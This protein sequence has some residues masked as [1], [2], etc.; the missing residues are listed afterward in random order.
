MIGQ[1]HNQK[2]TAAC[3]ECQVTHRTSEVLL[4]AGTVPL[5]TVLL[6]LLLA[7]IVT[8]AA[9]GWR[10]LYEVVLERQGPT[11]EI[12]E[13]PRGIGIAPI[14]LRVLLKDNGSGLDEV[15]VRTIQRGVGKEVLR[16]TLEGRSR[17]EVS[18]DFAG[19]KSGLDEGVVTLEI[20]AFDRSFWSNQAE[21]VL[22]LKV[23][24]RRPRLE[25]LTSF[26]NARRGGSQ[27]IFYRVSDESLAV[28]GVKVGTTT[29]LGYSARG[30]DPAF[31]DPTIY[32]AFYAIDLNANPE[33]VSIKLF[34]E[35]VVGNAA[36]QSFSNKVFDRAQRRINMPMSEVL[37][38]GRL[39]D[40]VDTNLAKIEEF[41]RSRGKTVNLTTGPGK[42]DRL[43][44]KF[45]LLNGP[46]REMSESQLLR[47]LKASR[48][49][50]YWD[51]P[52]QTV[53]GG[54]NLA[55]GD[56]V[57]FVLDRAPIGDTVQRGYEVLMS[58]DRPEVPALAG[59]IVML[60]DTIGVFGRTVAIDHGFGL[61]TIYGYLDTV[62]VRQG[63]KI[64]AGQPI[65]RAGESGLARSLSTFIQMRVHG[66]SV[67]PLEWWDRTWYN[68]HIEGKIN[69]VKRALGLEV[70]QP[71]EKR[72]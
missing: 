5:R 49:E 23:D 26:H 34:A 55:F 67:D 4:Q 31:E 18:V 53:A 40:L 25:P 57:S 64:V 70:L 9:A 41:E 17:V 56:R 36:S 16:R 21:Q 12:I 65:G 62:M 58:R 8:L 48:F 32:A 52:F 13:Q 33:N 46:L 66:V 50:R 59:G 72:F 3:S 68:G 14:T 54:I 24:Y 60:S 63:E 51:G 6:V 39:S 29:F 15:L 30:L 2:L 28:S 43:I 11:I 45:S 61:V 47:S 69:E 7:M 27:L 42:N 44:A 19:E 1:R 10:D 38:R 20:R 22:N 71:L 35:D 37:L